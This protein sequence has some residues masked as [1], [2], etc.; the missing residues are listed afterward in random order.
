ML[1][2][3]TGC[4]S[5]MSC[6]RHLRVW[7]AASVWARPHQTL[8]VLKH[9][10]ERLRDYLAT[11][12]HQRHHEDRTNRT[13]FFYENLQGQSYNEDTRPDLLGRFMT[14]IYH[15]T[16]VASAKCI[17]E[18]GLRVR[19]GRIFVDSCAAFY[20]NPGDQLDTATGALM[21]FWWDGEEQALGQLFDPKTIVK[22]ILYI[23]GRDAKIFPTSEP[24]LVFQGIAI[25]YPPGGEPSEGRNEDQTLLEGRVL[26][27]G[28][29][30]VANDFRGGGLFSRSNPLQAANDFFTAALYRHLTVD[31]FEA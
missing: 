1:P 8:L 9:K 28:S 10:N 29:D 12:P 5:G 31:W 25:G 23:Q 22:N 6:W 24:L 26:I 13:K 17:V 21:E 27:A 20:T 30:W 4:D 11:E 18:Q 7:Q 14:T 16:S 3:E 15:A 2:A 19:D